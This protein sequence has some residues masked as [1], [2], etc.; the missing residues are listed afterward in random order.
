MVNI[1]SDSDTRTHELEGVDIDNDPSKRIRDLRRRTCLC[2][3]DLGATPRISN[4][5]K[6]LS[7]GKYRIHRPRLLTES[8]VTPPLRIISASPS[9]VLE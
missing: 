1:K 2:Q 6:F 8:Y 9:G 4:L 3:W 7:F 5:H